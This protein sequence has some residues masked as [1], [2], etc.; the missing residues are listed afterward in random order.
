MPFVAYAPQ[1]LCCQQAIARK[2][3]KQGSTTVNLEGRGGGNES[4]PY[5]GLRGGLLEGVFSPRT[6]A[7]AGSLF[8]SLESIYALHA[9]NAALS[10]GLAAADMGASELAS[11]LQNKLYTQKQNR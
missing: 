1:L 2:G 7:D 10:H 9:M 11:G 5:G 4:S 8:H 6:F 3:E